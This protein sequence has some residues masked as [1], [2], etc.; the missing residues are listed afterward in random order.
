MVKV[1]GY[2]QTDGYDLEQTHRWHGV[3]IILKIMGVSMNWREIV[4]GGLLLPLELYFQPSRFRKR[5]HA[6][7]PELD[8][9]YSL[10]QARKYWKKRG[11]LQGVTA[12][13]LEALVSFVWAPIVVLGWSI[14]DIEVSLSFMVLSLL[15]AIAMGI[16]IS[17]TLG[18]AFSVL[19]NITSAIAIGI[20]GDISLS[21]ATILALGL[22]LNII[23]TL[24]ASPLFILVFAVMTSIIPVL[25]ILLRYSE[26]S[27][28]NSFIIGL[29]IFILLLHLWLYPL[30]FMLHHLQMRRIRSN[31][32]IIISMW[33][34]HPV[35]LDDIIFHLCLAWISS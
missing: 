33:R 32:N 19:I 5:V 22:M 20:G 26:I 30:W 4:I 14:V 24:S 13:Y 17:L 11:F 31:P 35:H 28:A 29:I 34:W 7:A 6:L 12:L 1:L 15:C 8:E 25:S 21:L 3:Q 2:A 23:T 16:I 10:W 27:L 18:L 9:D